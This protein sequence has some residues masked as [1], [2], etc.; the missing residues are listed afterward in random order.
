MLEPSDD[1][2]AKPWPYGG[3]G[4]SHPGVHAR[5]HDGPGTCAHWLPLVLTSHVML[6]HVA[7]MV[8]VHVHLSPRVIKSSAVSESV[9]VVMAMGNHGQECMQCRGV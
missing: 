6:L 4:L 9:V 7:L 1:R 5:H 8:P 2:N 3:C